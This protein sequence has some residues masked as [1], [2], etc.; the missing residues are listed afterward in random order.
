MLHV[1]CT[2]GF[3]LIEILVVMALFSLILSTGIF[4]SLNSY[5][6]YSFFSEEN[7]LVTLIYKARSMAL[8]NV[9]GLPHGVHID[10]GNYVLFEGTPYNPNDSKNQLFE[11]NT[12]V[13][14]TGLDEILFNALSANPVQLG[15]I[16][17]SE[18]GQTKS[19]SIGDEG[20]INW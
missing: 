15:V 19:I 12:A 14:T 9:R 6:R 10:A 8:N 3:T 18:D 13:A 7:T 4:V 16:T 20:T 1:K 11:R 2:A 5:K 17:L